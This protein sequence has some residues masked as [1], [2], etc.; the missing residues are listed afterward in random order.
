MHT[1]IFIDSRIGKHYDI[2]STNEQNIQVFRDV[3]NSGFKTGSFENLKVWLKN[4]TIE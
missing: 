2:K 4:V 3:I 1:R